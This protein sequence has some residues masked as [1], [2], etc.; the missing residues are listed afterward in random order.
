MTFILVPLRNGHEGKRDGREIPNAWQEQVL[1]NSLDEAMR[2]RMSQASD[3]S[4]DDD[5][6][7][8]DV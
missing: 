3:S 6:D 8:A 2:T 5:D 7:A 4:S 1:E